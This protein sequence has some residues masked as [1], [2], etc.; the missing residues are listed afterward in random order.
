MYKEITAEEYK[1]YFGFEPDYRIEGFLVYGAWDVEKYT[2]EILN[3]VS[4]HGVEVSSRRLQSFLSDITEVIIDGKNYWVGVCYGS[5]KLSEYTHLA[6]LFGS[7]WV[8]H[9]G[10]AGG[11]S[12]GVHTLDIVIPD[13]SVAQDSVASLYHSENKNLALK[14]YVRNFYTEKNVSTTGGVSISI[15]AMMGESY[16]DILQWNK[17]G[18]TCVDM[19]SSTI[20]VVSN[21]FNVP[22][23]SILYISDNLLKEETVLSGSYEEQKMKRLEVKKVLH[24]SLINLIKNPPAFDGERNQLE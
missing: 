16:S 11:L 14:K 19:E 12:D 20:M 7:K 6:C 1:K 13:T 8:L 9:I 24:S 21:F 5:A 15:Q 10:S 18:Y 4:G 2:Q 3:E 23:A 17:S 22:S